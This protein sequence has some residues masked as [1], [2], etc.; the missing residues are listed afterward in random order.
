MICM[1]VL[2]AVQH[3]PNQVPS[4]QLLTGSLGDCRRSYAR[5]SYK[6]HTIANICEYA[7]IRDQQ[8]RWRIKND[9]VENRS[10][11]VKQHLHTAIRDEFAR[12][13]HFIPT[14]NETK[15]PFLALLN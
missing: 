5:A 1:R 12:V 14:R 6:Q 4:S 8:T 3:H 10:E 15:I 7:G 13:R 2:H 9:P 11:P